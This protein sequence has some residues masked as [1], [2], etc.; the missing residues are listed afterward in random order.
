MHDG[1]VIQEILQQAANQQS[2]YLPWTW[3]VFVL[4]TMFQQTVADAW[5]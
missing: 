5:E 4:P 1:S 2:E 3:Q